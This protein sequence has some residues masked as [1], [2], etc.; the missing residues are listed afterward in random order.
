VL[1]DKV[2]IHPL[3]AILEVVGELGM[4]DGLDKVLP[5]FKTV[6]RDPKRVVILVR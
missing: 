6:G 3:E 5:L 4:T 2:D 1:N